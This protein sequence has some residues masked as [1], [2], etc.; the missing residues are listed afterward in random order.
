VTLIVWTT[1]SLL[2]VAIVLGLLRVLTARDEASRAAVGD[3]VYF[4]SLSIFVV[5]GMT[6]GTA[7]L[8]DVASL[9][10]LLAIVATVALARILTRGR[11]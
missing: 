4:A 8:F 6:A 9:G 5:V 10:A 3:L 2:V 7:V 1:V 11:R